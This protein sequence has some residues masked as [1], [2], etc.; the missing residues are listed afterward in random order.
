M[1][2][3]GALLGDLR[4]LATLQEYSETKDTLGVAVYSWTTIGTHYIS[5][6]GMTSKEALF[7]MQPAGSITHEIRCRYS[8]AIKMSQRFLV[9]S[10]ILNIVS[11]P[12]DPTGRQRWL[13]IF[14]KE[15]VSTNAST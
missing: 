12:V 2:S 7:A 9:G 10:R 4:T 5:I 14:V 13:T 8:S 3:A 11:P 6:L 15:E 1:P